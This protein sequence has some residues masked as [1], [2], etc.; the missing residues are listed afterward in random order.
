MKEIFEKRALRKRHRAGEKTT[1]I[2][3]LSPP[4]RNTL[5]IGVVLALV[6]VAWSCLAKVPIEVNGTGVLLPVGKINQIRAKVG[7]TAHWMFSEKRYNWI[8][9]AQQFKREPDRISDTAV[10]DLSRNILRAYSN[11]Q[12]VAS[13]Q[14]SP[15]ISENKIYP[16]GALLIWLQSLKEQKSLQS[17]VDSLILIGRLNRVKQKNLVLKQSILEKELISRKNF[18]NQMS[19]LADQGFVSKP[20]LLEN[21]ATV[22]NLE[23]QIFTNRD[24]LIKLQ[25]D[26][27]QSF[28]KLRQSL[29]QLISN[30]F[31]FA[32]HDVYIRQ[33]APN[34]GEAVLQGDPLLLLSRQ[35]LGNPIKI[36]IFLSE[37]E[38]SQVNVGMSV[39]VTPV[40]MR[41]S[42]V[43]GMIGR[44][45]E[46]S[47]L[48][49][50]EKELQS[51]IGVNTLATVIQQREPSPTLAI[52][53][54][55]RSPED[56]QGNRG[57]YVWNSNGDLPF[58]PKTADQ[59]GVSIT[60]RK[61]TPISLI[62]P[63]LRLLLGLTP[64]EPKRKGHHRS[65]T[66]A[67]SSVD[68]NQVDR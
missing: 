51:R 66:S 10:L 12:F 35:S 61:V 15:S 14:S 45:V 25:T 42:E 33:I 16:Q 53:E 52:V 19:V 27:Q 63:R 43:G 9:E 31:V 28:I 20:T 32:E 22:D 2:V 3:V 62:I 49:I 41:R 50:G 7:G 59:L 56:L 34:N 67:S 26:I 24:S 47:E 38:S 8:S 60:T 4:L 65:D 64:P 5:G 29:A 46:M 44:V 13:S 37:R 6:G 55:K 54:L 1:P 11:P 23:S 68:N 36:P 18:L 17:Q 58:A 40:G 48:P 30:S 39:L 21:Q 57:G